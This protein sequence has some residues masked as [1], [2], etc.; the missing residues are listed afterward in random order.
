MITNSERKNKSNIIFPPSI[1]EKFLRNFGNTKVMVTSAAP[2]FFAAVLEYLCYEILDLYAPGFENNEGGEGTI[3]LDFNK[4]EM[5]IE[6]SQN[7]EESF[8][9]SREEIRLV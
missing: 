1:V 8:T 5:S 3:Y 9:G 6:Y 2:I 7:Y 4:K